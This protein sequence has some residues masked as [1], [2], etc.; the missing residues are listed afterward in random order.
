[1][2]KYDEALKLA[3][4]IDYESHAFRHHGLGVLQFELTEEYRVHL[5]HP[6]LVTLR[7]YRGIHD[8]RFLL[9]SIILK[10]SILNIDFDDTDGTQLKIFEIT[11]AKIQRGDGSDFKY[12]GTRNVQVTSSRILQAGDTYS[13]PRR[14]F[15]TSIPL[16]PAL[17]LIRR[18]D[19]DSS[20]ARVI[21]NS[22]ESGVTSAIHAHSLVASKFK[23]LINEILTACQFRVI[24][25]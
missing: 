4:S 21:G 19:F 24:G 17:T 12:L 7:G 9:Q 15:H 5:W 22:T 8:H 23:P 14:Q 10:G 16:E 13:I 6:E 25:D 20:P 3:Q 1:M 11:H 18:S 2:L